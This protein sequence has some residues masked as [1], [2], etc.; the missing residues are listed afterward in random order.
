MTREEKHAVLCEIDLIEKWR[1]SKEGQEDDTVCPINAPV[2]AGLVRQTWPDLFKSR[3][4]GG[5]DKG[6]SLRAQSLEIAN[7][8]RAMYDI[9]VRD[10]APQAE[11]SLGGTTEE[12]AQLVAVECLGI[13]TSLHGQENLAQ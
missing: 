2:L 11:Q 4:G 8:A 10:I 1:A 3:R 5:E 7:N 6:V 13:A 9:M 12:V